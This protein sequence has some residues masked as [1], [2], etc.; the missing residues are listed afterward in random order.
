LLVGSSVGISDG[1]NNFNFALPV[2]FLVAAFWQG[3]YASAALAFFKD[4]TTDSAIIP[5]TLATLGFTGALVVSLLGS[6]ALL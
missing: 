6:G 4:F 3:L 2:I 5:Q 1:V